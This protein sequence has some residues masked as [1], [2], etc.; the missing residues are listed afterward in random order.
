MFRHLLE[1]VIGGQWRI[2]TGP[3]DFVK[4]VPQG[5]GTSWMTLAE[6]MQSH[7]HLAGLGYR[8]K[9]SI[10]GATLWEMSCEDVTGFMLPLR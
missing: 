6:I 4:K 9:G 3:H 1:G 8:L 10:E 2:S 5:A 7:Q